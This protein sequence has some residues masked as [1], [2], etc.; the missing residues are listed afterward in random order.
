MKIKDKISIDSLYFGVMLYPMS[1]SSIEE[2]NTLK[3][4]NLFDSS[5]VK[6]SV[7]MWVLMSPEE[8]RKKDFLRWCFFDVWGRAEYE[9][10]VCPW[11]YTDKDTID[12]VGVKVDTWTMY[13][14]P[15]KDYLRELVDKVTK[16]S[17]RA[18]LREQRKEHRG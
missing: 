1:W 12:S 13:V 8:K 9:F 14:E 17:A 2:R 3:Q 4:Y 7:A 18:Y 16:S 10:V 6:R 11:P 15:N 5:R